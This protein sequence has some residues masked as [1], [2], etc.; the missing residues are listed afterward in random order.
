MSI[1]RK[2]N[3][4]MFYHGM[5]E[6]GDEVVVEVLVERSIAKSTDFLAEVQ[7][8]EDM[9]LLYAATSITI[10]DGKKSQFWEAPW[11]DIAPLVF[12]SSK[13]KKWCVSQALHEDAWIG[14]ITWT[15]ASIWGMHVNSLT[16]GFS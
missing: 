12:V 8:E 16:F 4:G 13:R 10:G 7:R 11:L 2:G 1:I 6:N 5:L 15:R 3:F 9:D 14:K